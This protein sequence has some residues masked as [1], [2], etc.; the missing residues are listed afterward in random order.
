MIRRPPRSTLYPYTTLFRSTKWKKEKNKEFFDSTFIEK[1][2]KIGKILKK[3]SS[4]KKRQLYLQRKSIKQCVFPR[5]LLKIWNF[6]MYCLLE[7]I[8][9]ALFPMQNRKCPI[10]RSNNFYCYEPC[11]AWRKIIREFWKM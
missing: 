9:Q 7:S 11:M 2:H 8:F 3:C 6:W 1:K 4:R 10:W 5:Y